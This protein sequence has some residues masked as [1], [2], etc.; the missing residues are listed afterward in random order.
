MNREEALRKLADQGS[1]VRAEAAAQLRAAGL[2]IVANKERSA[3]E[4]EATLDMW[5]YPHPVQL[6]GRK[7][8]PV[9]DPTEVLA[10]KVLEL[11]PVDGRELTD[12]FNHHTAADWNG[13]SDDLR[14]LVRYG[15][16]RGRLPMVDPLELAS[17]LRAG[18]LS[19]RL[20]TLQQE[21]TTA[22]LAEAAEE[23]RR[24]KTATGSALIGS[25]D[26]AELAQALA[27][28]PMC[29]RRV[30]EGGCRCSV[31]QKPAPT[32][33]YELLADLFEPAELR[34]FVGSY[35]HRCVNSIAWHGAPRAVAYDVVMQL[36]NHGVLN[37][38]FWRALVVERP[39]R[40]AEIVALRD[41]AP[42]M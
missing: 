15:V 25:Y 12:G 37:D 23:L 29:G 40:A 32:R 38:E 41:S 28:C 22:E 42:R 18:T 10:K 16:K 31:P 13:V 36:Q 7:R 20:R 35:Y 8:L 26:D 24:V 34:R 27:P 39:G 2:R 4:V 14:A 30:T 6:W 33:L 3:V 21:A 5:E 1:D 9:V 17:Q 11:D 19:E